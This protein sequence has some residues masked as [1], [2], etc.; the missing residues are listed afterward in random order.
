MSIGDY[1]RQT[2][3]EDVEYCDNLNPDLN[4]L[5]LNVGVLEIQML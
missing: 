5:P 1:V 3:K 4:P 2:S